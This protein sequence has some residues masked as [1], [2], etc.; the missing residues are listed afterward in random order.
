MTCCN[1][2]LT[3]FVNAASTTVGYGGNKPTVTVTYLIDGVWQTLGV[4]P[5]ITFTASNVIVD[6]GGPNTGVI[7][8]VQ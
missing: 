2:I 4:A 1:I 5:V 6:H 3:T 8:F 7:K